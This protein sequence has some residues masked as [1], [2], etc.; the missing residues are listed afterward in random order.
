MKL[1]WTT[2]T[3]EQITVN[4]ECTAYSGGDDLQND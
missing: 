3:F 1:E 4:M 2:P